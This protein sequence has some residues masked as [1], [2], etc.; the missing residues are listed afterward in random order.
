MTNTT[1]STTGWEVAG[2]KKNIIKKETPKEL[3][4]SSKATLESAA[5][6]TKPETIGIFFCY[7][8]PS[9]H[10]SKQFSNLL[11]K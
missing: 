7:I 9:F 5:K 11:I 3:L 10:N 8:Y 6:T 1:S 4:K 2:G